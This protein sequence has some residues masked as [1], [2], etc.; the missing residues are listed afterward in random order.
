MKQKNNP[1]H[2][3]ITLSYLIF[4][5]I[6]HSV[7]AMDRTK[8]MLSPLLPQQYYR[9]L[10]TLISIILLAPLPWLPWPRGTLYHI[11]APLSYG[12]YTLQLFGLFGL[13]WTLRH[14]NLSDFLGWGH[15]Q[16]LSTSPQLITT[17]PYRLCRHPLYFWISVI[18]ITHPHPTYR[19]LIFTLW[20]VLYF[21]IGSYIEE[22]RLILQ[23]GEAYKTYQT[24]TARLIPFLNIKI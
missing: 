14:T 18:C 2:L 16:K 7:L 12:F 21:W 6:L 3:T 4:Y 24:H 1:M 17:G 8:K 20:L 22:R 9:L 11:H 15:L 10:Y 5:A 19:H 13:L 23:F